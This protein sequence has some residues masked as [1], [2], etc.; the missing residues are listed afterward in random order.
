[1]DVEALECLLLSSGSAAPESQQQCGMVPIH[2][3]LS[4]RLRLLREPGKERTAMPQGPAREH[5]ASF[6]GPG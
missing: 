4:V 5:F 1:M 6:C 2:C 3:F